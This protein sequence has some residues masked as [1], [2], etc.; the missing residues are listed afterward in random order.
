MDAVYN[1]LFTGIPTINK[2]FRKLSDYQRVKHNMRYRKAEGANKCGN[3]GNHFKKKF[4]KVYHK[5]RLVGCSC[6]HATDIR[7]GNVCDHW[8]EV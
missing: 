1:D 4:S 5:C 3:C 8:K 6:S 2:D 7:V